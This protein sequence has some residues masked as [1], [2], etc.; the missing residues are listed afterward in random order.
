M[1]IGEVVT[2]CKDGDIDIHPEFQRI[3]RWR[4]E[5]K[6][7]LIESVLL[8]IPIPPIFV[9]QREDGVWDVIDGV[10]RLS[11]ILEFTGNYVN[12][13]G[14]RQ[15]GFVL[16]AGEYLTDMEGFAYE[17]EAT[18]EVQGADNPPVIDEQAEDQK[19]ATSSK[20][21]DDVLKRDFKRAKLEFRII[22]K[23]SDPSAKYDLFSEAELGQRAFTPRGS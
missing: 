20:A 6:S 19:L 8:G 13:D 1:S 22:T 5:Q 21:F 4:D 9:S 14:H 15:S 12:E 11:T 7:R 10:Q 23:G 18:R 2:L 16:S 17:A 3:F